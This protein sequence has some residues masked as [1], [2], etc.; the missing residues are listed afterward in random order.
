MIKHLIVSVGIFVATVVSAQSATLTYVSETYYET[1]YVESDGIIPCCG[2]LLG[3]YDPSMS[4]MFEFRIDGILESNAIYST[5]T[6][7]RPAGYRAMRLE[8]IYASDGISETTAPALSLSADIYTDADGMIEQWSIFHAFVPGP[9]DYHFVVSNSD[10]G[11]Y[12]EHRFEHGVRRLDPVTGLL[13]WDC[14]GGTFGRG[15]ARSGTWAVD[16]APLVAS[17]PPA[18]PLPASILLYCVALLIFGWRRYRPSPC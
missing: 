11:D 7:Y 2:P 13:V 16:G 10:T 3:P 12:A 6:D 8:P 4:L 15:D 1:E 14:C 5:D 17:D 18:V 9:P